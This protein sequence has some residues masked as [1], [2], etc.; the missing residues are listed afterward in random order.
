M[1]GELVLLLVGVKLLGFR[2]GLYIAV[3]FLVYQKLTQ[4]LSGDRSTF[5]A[6]SSKVS[7][8][9]HSRTIHTP[10]VDCRRCLRRKVRAQEVSG[11]TRR[12]FGYPF[13]TVTVPTDSV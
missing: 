8:Y 6:D 9:N 7:I 13:P 3:F 5:H 2:L 11:R 4:I 10:H 1:S 12:W